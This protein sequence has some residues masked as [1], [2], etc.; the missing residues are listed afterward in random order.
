MQDVEYFDVYSPVIN[1]KY[2]E[3]KEILSLVKLSKTFP[4]VFWTMMDPV[5]LDKDIVEKFKGKTMAVVGYETDQV[6][7]KSLLK[8][9]VSYN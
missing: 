6:N 2:S 9:I 4:K 8:W 1:S 3:V 7:I 5:P